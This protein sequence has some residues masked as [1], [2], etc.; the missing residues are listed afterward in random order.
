MKFDIDFF[1]KSWYGKGELR[2][3][4][5]CANLKEKDHLEDQGIE[6]VD[7]LYILNYF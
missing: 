3:G 1:T 4:F 2:T 6:E 5:W 7:F